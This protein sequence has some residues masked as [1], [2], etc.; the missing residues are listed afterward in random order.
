MF[1]KMPFLLCALIC[2]AAI[3][4][5]WLPLYG[6]SL[7]YGMS[8]SLKSL[9][10]AALPFLIFGLIFKA[11][12]RIAKTA[13]KWILWIVAAVC[14]SNLLS[15]LLSYG[16]GTVAYHLPMVLPSL[17]QSDALLPIG[18]ISF[19][20]WIDNRYALVSGLI[21][22]IL[23]AWRRPALA[24]RLSLWMDRG[25][26]LILKGLLWIIPFF[27][28]GFVVRM[29]HE[30]ILGALLRQN[31]AVVALIA[32]SL[33]LYIGWLYLVANSFKWRASLRSL[34][35]MLPAAIAGFGSMSS[36]A[37]MPLTLIGTEKNAR[38]PELA[39][40]I[41]PV[42]VNIHLIGDCFAIPI[43]A[44][45]LM[46]GFGVPEPSLIGYLQFALYF[47]LAKFSVAAVPGGGILVMLPILESYLGFNADMLSLITALYILLDPLITSANVLGNG[48]FAMILSRWLKNSKEPAQP[49]RP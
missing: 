8:L 33:A 37:A 17:H 9:I 26:G 21:G 48:A 24:E 31:F 46:K 35:H 47:V 23:C 13:S 22:G 20:N 45:M 38:D 15:T 39:T 16:V 1:R 28:T 3:A 42:T 14:L 29:L 36:A 4:D 12:V 41:I 30:G 2:V 43:L 6:K 27:L 34:G 19:P 40:S 5:P 10:L 11:S 25:V 18:E 49:A 7:L 32:L 44:F